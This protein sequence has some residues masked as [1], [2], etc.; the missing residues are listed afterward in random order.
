MATLTVADM[1]DIANQLILNWAR[2]GSA[3]ISATKDFTWL[4]LDTIYLWLT[5][6]CFN[7]FYQESIHPF[8]N[9]VITVLGESGSRAPRLALVNKIRYK[10]NAKFADSQKLMQQISQGIVD[11]RRANPGVKKDILN[12][13]IRGV[14]S[15]T[16]RPLRGELVI[17][18]MITFLVAGESFHHY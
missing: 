18:Q 8:V 2:Q 14:D 16:G 10:A 9:A 17:A 7:S 11:H 4:T 15:K 5:D 3:R 6:Y 1:K 13:M 12:V